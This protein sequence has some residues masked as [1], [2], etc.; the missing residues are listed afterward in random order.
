MGKGFGFLEIAR[1]IRT[2]CEVEIP[3]TIYLAID[4]LFSRCAGYTCRLDLLTLI[5]RRDYLWRVNFSFVISSLVTS[6]T[7]TRL[8]R[9]LS[10]L[11]FVLLCIFV[12][13]CP[14]CILSV[15]AHA[16]SRATL[17]VGHQADRINDET[18]GWQF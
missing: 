7:G 5:L 3:F 8:G 9:L 2:Y 10:P 12:I 17:T 16:E 4:D 11:T 15:D 14:V 18:I 6:M 1:V 13:V